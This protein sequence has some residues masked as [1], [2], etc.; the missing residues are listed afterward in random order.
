MKLIQRLANVEDP[1]SLSNRLRSK[2]FGRFERLT[3]SLPRPLRIVDL[4]GT[5]EFW[6]QR[7]WA[8]RDDVLITI[9]NI[10][11][12]VSRHANCRPVYGDVTELSRFADHSFD[13]AFSNSVIEHLFTF[14]QQAAMAKELQRLAPTFWLQTPNYWFPIEPHFH[15]PGWQ[16]LPLRVRKAIIRRWRCGW[17]GPCPDADQA[18]EVVREVRLMTRNQL[19]LLFPNAA[20]VP[21]R[22]GGLVKSWVVHST[23][24]PAL[25]RG[26]A[27]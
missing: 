21:E 24:E 6:E 16:W 19:Q 12:R 5:P 18:D 23:N 27:A 22:F 13:V 10:Q 8:G 7:G 26:I 14:E 15:M 9:V 11:P 25:A 20:I 3:D 1:K 4:G 2:R 17:R